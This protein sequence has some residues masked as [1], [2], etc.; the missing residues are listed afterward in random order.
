MSSPSYNSN[1]SDS[2]NSI[3]TYNDSNEGAPYNGGNEGPSYNSGNSGNSGNAGYNESPSY[4][5]EF[6]N[7]SV[8]GINTD[9]ILKSIFYGAIFYLLSLP[10]VYKMTSGIVGKK[11]DGVLLHGVVFAILYYILT[12][13]I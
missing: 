8:G 11:V 6:S 3:D 4:N 1:N 2:Y 7:L 13:F 5:E 9:L 12:H 10:E